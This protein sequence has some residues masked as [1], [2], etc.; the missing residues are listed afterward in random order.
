MKKICI[1]LICLSVF[2]SFSAYAEDRSSTRIKNQTAE[3]LIFFPEKEIGEIFKAEKEGV[4]IPYKEY[5]SLYE[6]ARQEYG[7]KRERIILN[8]DIK[9]PQIVQAH[10]DGSVQ[11]DL[12]KV[13]V[14]YQIVQNDPE[15]R[16]LQLPFGIVEKCA[17]A[18]PC[19]MNAGEYLSLA[20]QT[21]G[22]KTR[23]TG[24]SRPSV[25]K[26]VLFLKATLNNENAHIYNDNKTPSL[27]IPSNG[28]F[29]LIID[30]FIPIN[31]KDKTGNIAIDIPPAMLGQVAISTDIF[32]DVRFKDFLLTS[33]KQVDDKM[34]FLGFLPSM[35]TS[36][37]FEI[38]NRRSSGEKR[39][40]IK[41]Q[42]KH[43]AFLSEDL[44]E[45]TIMYDMD[46]ENGEVDRVDIIIAKD[47]NIYD[48]SGSIISNWSRESK[49]DTDIL[50]LYFHVPLST[51]ITFA[52]KTYQYPDAA[53]GMFT[54]ADVRV[55][56]LFERKGILAVFYD[57]SMRINARQ[58]D[59][60]LPLSGE[61]GVRRQ[62]ESDRY[63]LFRE[64]HVFNLPYKI[65]F[66]QKDV[67]LE[68][69]LFQNNEIKLEH[70]RILFQSEVTLSGITEE[71]TR[72]NFQVPD[73]YV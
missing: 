26:N 22:K 48:I 21:S 9:G 7:E 40:K 11:G 18:R 10:Y 58:V 70:A 6:K 68:V 29:T 27:I 5:K 61:G 30:F 65:S 56:N 39:V 53:S 8:E 20:A 46:V 63:V 71:I 43:Q 38:T 34:E 31:F 47:L 41:S 17:D 36:L 4:L 35:E 60:L 16:V 3:T 14:R 59:F 33:K 52:L 51:G 55:E 13:S 49:E 57:D 2:F 24:V 37:S 42:E 12:L 62:H 69:T 54:L 23:Q 64:Y 50:H 73:K 25:S 19:R 15:P 66:S 28:T 1:S 72:F 44:I 45:Q 67:P 32:Y